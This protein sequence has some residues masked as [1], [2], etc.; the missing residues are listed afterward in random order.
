HARLAQNLRDG[1]FEV[2]PDKRTGAAR[3]PAVPP[4]VC[5]LFSK[6]SKTGEQWARLVAAQAGIEW[7]DLSREQRGQRIK[8][9]TQDIAGQQAKGQKDDVADFADWRRQAHEFGWEPPATLERDGPPLPA[10]GPEQRR[11]RAYQIALPLLAD[12][13]ARKAV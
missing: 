9:Y 1:G 5:A 4:D 6:R 10:I 3:L 7:D 11:R 8:R 2:V 12:E 13:F